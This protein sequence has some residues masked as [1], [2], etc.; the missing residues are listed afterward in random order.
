MR[1]KELL[2]S[3]LLGL[4]VGGILL[5][6]FIKGQ[7]LLHPYRS[8][9]PI[10]VKIQV[11]DPYGD[12]WQGSGV[13]VAD[14]LILTAGHVVCDANSI[15]I[16]WS[17]GKKHKA[18]NW[19]EES[20]ADLGII[21]IK[22]P[23]KESRIKFDNAVMGE[24][25]WALGNPHGIFPVLSKGIVSAINMT[26]HYDGQKDMVITDCAINAGNSGC[27]LFDRSGNILGICSWGFTHSQGMSY[28]VRAKIC[29]L[30][31]NKYYAIEALND[32]K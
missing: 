2:K 28:F 4:I 22:T 23:E 11:E 31:L 7:S 27:P 14:N 15:W 13:F 16:T 1:I 6:G 18:I 21:Y 25:V 19:Y 26:D 20:E 32:A 12:R 5:F 17:N 10:V 8:F 24:S 29:E 3:V 30:T 9:I